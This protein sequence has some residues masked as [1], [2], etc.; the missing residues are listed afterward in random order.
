MTEAV[1]VTPLAG[2]DANDDP[3]PAGTPFTLRGFVAPMGTTTEPGPDGDLDVVDYTVFLPL[4][5]KM[6]NGWVRTT[7]LLT[8][9]FTI[10]VRGQV[11]VGRAR[12]WDESGRGGVEVLASVKSGATI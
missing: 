10:T 3:L 8:D 9:N 2:L 11:C 5:V 7:V 6:P 12:E 1:V 4:K